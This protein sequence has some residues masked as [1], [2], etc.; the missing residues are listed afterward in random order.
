MSA[1]ERYLAGAGRILEQIAADEWPSIR[2]AAETVADT[3]AGDGLVHVFGTGHSHMLAEEMFYRAGGLAAI[4]PILIEGLMLHAG[5]ER[6][7]HLERQHGLAGRIFG[8]VPL[9]PGDTFIVASNSGGNAVCEELAQLAGEAGASVVAIVSSRHAEHS[10]TERD[11]SRLA[12]LADVVID[13]HG[14][15]G[16]AGVEIDGID[17][18][19]GPTST[20]AGAAIV[21]AV[22]AEAVEILLARGVEVDVF[23]SSNLPQ[24]DASNAEL[25]A[26]YRDRVRAL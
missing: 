9:K 21:N 8:D 23:T 12:E 17:R 15:I 4:N 16:D 26:R 11:G 7:T 5:A 20:V 10:A 6:S 14:D 22:V 25:V 2:A 18:K 3:I 13:N 19:V 1:G 24:G